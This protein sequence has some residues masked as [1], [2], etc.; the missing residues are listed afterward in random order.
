VTSRVALLSVHTCPLA[1]LGGK[2]TGGMNVY[3]R[4]VARE[5]GRLGYGVDV[6]TRNQDPSVPRVVPLGYGARVI[7]VTA[8]P[9]RPVSRRLLLGHLPAFADGIAAFAREAGTHYALAHGHYWLSGIAALEL[10]R[11]FGVPV[12]QMFH[13]LGRRKDLVAREASERELPERLEAESRLAREADRLVAAT[14]AERADLAWYCGAD[15]SRVRVIPCGVDV[16]LFRPGEQAA[17]RARLGL[18]PG[19]ILLFVGRLTPIKG[20]ETLLRALARL[21]S[22]PRAPGGLRLRIVGGD[23]DERPDGERARLRR[24]AAES[25]VR[26]SVD[27]HGPQAQSALPDYYRAADLCLI[28]SRH[29]SFGMV[30]LEAMASGLPVIASRVGGLRFTV[31]DGTTGLLV[32]EGDDAALAAAITALLADGSRRRELGR[33][34]V[35]WAQSFAW[36]CVA[37]ALAGLYAELIPELAPVR[38]DPGAARCTAFRRDLEHAGILG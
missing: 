14:P 32:P 5:L 3:V 29:E 24:L 35:E 37:R 4:E 27:F 26:A 13:T 16:D 36:P 25:G 8:G 11:R 2:E 10:G 20:L 28:P 23:R 33:K 7:H 34:A 22:E 31:R 21:V 9:R 19:P 17:A 12:V 1:A 15:L 38:P 6:F 18:G 30:A